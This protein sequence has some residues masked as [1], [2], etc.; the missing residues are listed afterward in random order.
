[1]SDELREAHA[2]NLLND[3]LLMEAFD[4][5][6]EEFHRTWLNTGVHDIETREQAW[7][8]IRLLER[9]KLHLH[10]YVETGEIAKKV[11]EFKI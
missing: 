10:S 11:K 2:R 9:L 8:M 5:M 1:M 3:K 6:N 7:V 4:A